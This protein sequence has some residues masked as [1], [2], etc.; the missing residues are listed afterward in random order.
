MCD[1]IVGSRRQL[2]DRDAK[3]AQAF[4]GHDVLS[5]RGAQPWHGQRPVSILPLSMI[6]P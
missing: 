4:A 5:I 1:R 3:V 2:A 6:R